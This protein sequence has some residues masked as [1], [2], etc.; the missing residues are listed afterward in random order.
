MGTTAQSI[1]EKLT[2]GIDLSEEESQEMIVGMMEGVFQPQEIKE[3]LLALRKKGEALSEVVGAA[4]AMRRKA[5][6]ITVPGGSPVDT[7]GTGGDR[8]KTFNIS[9][10]AALIAAGAGVVVA[11]HGNRSITSACGSADLLET[12]GVRVDVEPAVVE[13]C[14]RE[15]GFGFMFAPRFHPAMK[16]VAPIRKELGV[17]TIFNLLGPLTNPAQVRHQV[18]G[19]ADPAKLD[20]Y[21]EALRALGAV[22]ALVVHAEDGQDELSVT[23]PTEVRELQET[24]GRYEIASYTVTPEQFGMEPF[25]L[26]DLQGGTAADNARIAGEIL[27]GSGSAVRVAV[28]LNAAAAIYVAG[29]AKDIPEGMRAAA[30][31]ID[32]G[33]AKQV[34]EK[35]RQITHE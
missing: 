15:T 30:R 16:Q 5:T 34:L 25:F 6:S 27:N 24:N 12:L 11:K 14:I 26:A 13:R 31:S 32:S 33:R 2:Q 4:R 21:A 18:V 10:L 1:L 8:L 9:T 17:S 35:V 3:L 19:V 22:K 20:L 23:G 7:C 29:A 28:V